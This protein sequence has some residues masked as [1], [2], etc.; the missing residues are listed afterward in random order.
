MA[1]GQL[2]NPVVDAWRLDPQALT[3]GLAELVLLGGAD[4]LPSRDLGELGRDDGR[5]DVVDQVESERLAVLADV[6]QS[7]ADRVGDV[8]QVDLRAVLEDLP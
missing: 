5:L 4:H 6:G 3:V 7:L 8:S 2:A 1:P